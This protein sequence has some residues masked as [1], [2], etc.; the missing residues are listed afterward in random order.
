MAGETVARIEGKSGNFAG[1][2]AHTIRVVHSS[3]AGGGGAGHWARTHFQFIRVVLLGWTGPM[4]GK[5]ETCQSPKSTQS[6]R[7]VSAHMSIDS[8]GGAKRSRHSRRPFGVGTFDSSSQ[9]LVFQSASC[10][11]A[12]QLPTVSGQ[13]ALKS[14]DGTFQLSC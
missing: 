14:T 12:E 10:Y 4:L 6:V 9:A 2:S 11:M 5:V 8:F 7:I 3:C 13:E 1:I